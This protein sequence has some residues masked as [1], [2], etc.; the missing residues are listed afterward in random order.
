MLVS[1]G[2]HSSSPLPAWPNCFLCNLSSGSDLLCRHDVAGRASAEGTEGGLQLRLSVQG[3]HPC[4]ARGP[5]GGP[6]VPQTMWGHL[7]VSCTGSVVLEANSSRHAIVS[8]TGWP[9][10]IT[11]SDPEDPENVTRCVKCSTIVGD[12]GAVL[13][14]VRVGQEALEKASSLQFS[15]RRAWRRRVW[16]TQR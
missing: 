8:L 16:N 2:F 10:V 4:A 13:D 7:P 3:L 15:G 14:A 12:M 11:D 9:F 1:V 5:A 6:M